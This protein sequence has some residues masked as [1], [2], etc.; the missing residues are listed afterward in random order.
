MGLHLPML[1]HQRSSFGGSSYSRAYTP[2]G[3]TAFAEGPT[4]G[5]CGQ[6]CERPMGTYQLGNGYRCYSPTALRFLSPDRHSPFGRGGSTHMAIVLVIQS[7]GVILVGA[8]GD[9]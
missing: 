6:L 9:W 7:I 8:G 3:A 1:D 4:L 5:F 2:Y